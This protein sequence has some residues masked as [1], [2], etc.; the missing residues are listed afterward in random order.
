MGVYIT[1]TITSGPPLGLSSIAKAGYIRV[2]QDTGLKFIMLKIHILVTPKLSFLKA[3][4]YLDSQR[5]MRSL[6]S[7]FSVH[8]FW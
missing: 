4:R 1:E 7:T 8:T 5:G 3:L 6:I 2:Q